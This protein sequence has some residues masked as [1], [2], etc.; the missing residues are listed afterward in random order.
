MH[1]FSVY[2]VAILFLILLAANV[3]AISISDFKFCSN[4]PEGIN[5]E[6]WE[7]SC[8]PIS[9]ANISDTFYAYYTV[10]DAIH[11]C[12]FDYVVQTSAANP[13]GELYYWPNDGWYLTLEDNGF[14][15]GGYRCNRWWFNLD[16]SKTGFWTF[17]F[18]AHDLIDDD[19][20]Y[21]DDYIH[22]YCES[23]FDCGG[24]G[25]KCANNDCMECDA[26]V[27]DQ[28]LSKE[29]YGCHEKI[30]GTA[31]V[32]NSG[33]VPVEYTFNTYLETPSGELLYSW[34]SPSYHLDPQQSEDWWFYFDPPSAG[35]PEEG[36]YM[37]YMYAVDNCGETDA[38]HAKF[39]FP[40][41]SCSEG[42]NPGEECSADSECAS[43][44][45]EG[46]SGYSAR[47]CSSQPPA[48]G[49]QGGGNTADCGN[50][51]NSNYRDYY[52]NSSGNSQYTTTST[53]NCDNQDICNNVCN[54][55]YKADYKD[56]FVIEN[57]NSC[58]YNWGPQNY[59]TYGCQ[60]GECI[61][62]DECSTLNYYYCQ[63]G[64]LYKCGYYDVDPYLDLKLIDDCGPGE[65][66]T[67]QNGGQS[68]SCQQGTQTVE[69]KVEDA[70]YA[71]TVYKQAG[72]YLNV[73]LYSPTSQ[74]V[75]FEFNESNFEPISG[76]C[77]NGNISLNAG[78]NYCK[79]LVK[80]TA[81]TGTYKFKAADKSENVAITD[82]PSL[83]IITNKEKLKERYA[84][85]DAGVKNLLKLA[86]NK[87]YSEKG[88]VYDLEEYLS[89]HPFATF[90][91]YDSFPLSPSLNN[92]ENQY[93]MNTALFA[94]DKCGECKNIILLGD[95]FI[96]PYYRASYSDISG[97]L[98]WQTTETEYI[99]TDQPSIPTAMKPFSEIGDLFPASENV[100]FVVASSMQGSQEV[101]LL[102]NAIE[103][104]YPGT[105]V[106]FVD[107]GTVDCDNP[108]MYNSLKGHTLV[109]IGTRENN[110]AIACLPWFGELED[111]IAI[112]R[113]VWGSE[114]EGYGSNQKTIKKYA[115][116]I[117]SE[118]PKI[119]E[120]V[121]K[122]VEMD[123]LGRT[124]TNT[125]VS[126]QTNLVNC[127]LVGVVPGIDTIGDA[128]S[129]VDDCGHV[130]VNFLNRYEDN[131]GRGAWCVFDTVAVFVPVFSASWFKVGKK[132]INESD[133][134]ARGFV[135]LGKYEG[136]LVKAFGR[137]GNDAENILKLVNKGVSKRVVKAD[138]WVT[139]KLGDYMYAVKKIG[140]N[141]P[142]ELTTKHR[143]LR[144][145]KTS[146]SS[147][148]TVITKESGEV[149]GEIQGVAILKKGEHIGPNQGWGW[150]HIVGEGHNNQIK[151]AFGLADNDEAVKDFI[152][153]GIERGKKDIEDPL[154]ILYQPEGSTKKLRITLSESA[155][156]SI[157][158]ARP[159]G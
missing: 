10:N 38:P 90:G 87:A 47:C 53:K 86:Y 31:K 94:R 126:L 120:A 100:K 18:G 124:N 117:N 77:A 111:S 91:D 63:S 78:D 116:V 1:K 44:Y 146:D 23:M 52:C 82:L 103:T 135:A 134:V 105:Y 5:C 148:K 83:L 2:S 128:C 66:C 71:V 107:P 104:K 29:T 43:G 129:I 11:E 84:T 68:G 138:L 139:N 101:T 37:L 92:N 142:M 26:T 99:Y 137:F 112:E 61:S 19:F 152:V 65:T 35:W 64:D 28:E 115:L 156:G 36:Y 88:I 133:D 9:S 75:N 143:L 89:G 144:F 127:Q 108:T 97:W 3:F 158:T 27:V 157:Q 21:H 98:F 114:V 85:N 102:K 93:A 153:E 16:S 70:A 72:D 60:N 49:W 154:I 40:Y 110:N 58:T 57:S 131:E 81:S 67:L 130:A 13:N 125:L 42:K 14:Q 46:A 8:N 149:V 41:V 109:L 33:E 54:G 55:S 48:D 118:N 159:Q 136:D 30:E 22:L 45:C 24:F 113:N 150:E 73:T 95:D 140:V 12:Y 39:L 122:F 76:V 59:C 15:C 74:I 51:P 7:A 96:V 62:G 80:E 69:V 32:F 50:D 141:D 56:Y 151:N 34:E 132:V 20:Y 79:F 106:S 123:M 147:I 145:G 155:P 25:W 121:S 6:G 119:L 4:W 17:D